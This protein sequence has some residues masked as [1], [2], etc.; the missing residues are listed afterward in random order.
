M[1][2]L[3]V[4]KSPT[5][6]HRLVDNKLPAGSRCTGVAMTSLDEGM[7]EEFVATINGEEVIV[8]APIE[9]SADDVADALVAQA[10]PPKHPP[11]L[12]HAQESAMVEG[13]EAPMDEPMFGTEGEPQADTEEYE[14]A[15]EEA[16]DDEDDASD[17]PKPKK[18][19]T[20]K[21]K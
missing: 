15:D 3:W 1:A 4:T 21:K 9:E 12:E 18:A 19:K 6:V 11:P 13:A 17:T 16:E 14:Y 10:P 7:V 5:D 2:E 20:K 8:Q